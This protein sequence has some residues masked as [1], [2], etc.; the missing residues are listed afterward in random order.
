VPLNLQRNENDQLIVPKG[1]AELRQV[2][3]DGNY[4]LMWTAIYD[5]LKRRDD[6]NFYRDPE[7]G[8][9]HI[10]LCLL[11]HFHLV[12]YGVSIR[13]AWVSPKGKEVI[14]FLEQYG[15]DWQDKKQPEFCDEWDTWLNP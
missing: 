3:R 2:I 8:L 12:D 7:T 4:D 10:L 15:R 1:V 14:E 11:D 6:T 9:E 13:G 5:E